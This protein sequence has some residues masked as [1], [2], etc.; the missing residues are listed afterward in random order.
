VRATDLT[1][2][3]PTRERW[4]ILRRT[5]DALAAQTITGFDTVV[6][7][8]G[9]DQRPPTDLADVRIVQVPRGGPG[10]ARNAGV[11]HADRPLV[12]FL[13]D[14][15]IP[16]PRL[17]ERH[18]AGHAAEPRR[19]TVVLGHIDWHP[20]VARSRLLRW[21]DWSDSQFDFASIPVAGPGWGHFVSSNVS[22]KRE[23][24]LEVGG[25][26][27]AFEFDYEDLDLAYR[28]DKAGMQLRHDEAALAHH[29]H[30]YDWAALERRYRG[31]ARGEWL[32]AHKHEWF[33][34]FFGG[35]VR[36]AAS[37]P[38]V[39]SVWRYLADVAPGR[40][41][42][43]A[44]P[45]ANR[46]YHQRLAP[47]YIDAWDG[48]RDLDDL[49][50]YLGPG[51]E[52]RRLTHHLQEVEAEEAAAP[53]EASFYR[54]SQAYLY[55]LTV[56][57]MS[58]TKLPYRLAL[59]RVLRP[60]SRLLDYGCGIGADGLRFIEAGYHVDFAD[61][62]NPSV[63][64]LRWRLKRRQIDAEIY[65]VE[66]HVPG[67]YDG[68][69][70]FDV[71]EHVDDPHA[72]LDELESRARVVAVNF[73]EPVADDVHVHKPLPVAELVQRARRHG[74]LHYRRYHG[75]SHLVIYRTG[76]SG[77]LDRARAAYVRHARR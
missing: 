55:D 40:L 74:L 9:E 5:L 43:A 62:T 50:D 10:A 18:L 64:Y 75:R 59:Q 39:S 25:F 68:V 47:A 16:V 12:L 28:L 1:V 57:A 49:R 51:Y 41:G 14:D 34:P 73:L 71:I 37:Q 8:D 72:F 29:L 45:K 69:Y 67:G 48:E 3:I 13:G 65:D 52:H 7:V 26:D 38:W 23:F 46:F 11:G 24:L 56:F 44:R 61:F 66:R 32:M 27:S 42:E 33:K 15:M 31:R 6:V 77:P 36:Y 70:C 53:D 58:G 19:E 60:G 4:Q 30:S 76:P 22:L 63:E 21:L 17:V 35:R 20:D 54:T 2:I